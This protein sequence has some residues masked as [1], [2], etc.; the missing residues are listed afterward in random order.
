MQQI[1]QGLN[2]S[3]RRPEAPSPRS[4]S[5]ASVTTSLPAP[6][7]VLPPHH[8]AGAYTATPQSFRLEIADDQRSVARR[9][10]DRP[11]ARQALFNRRRMGLAVCAILAGC[12]LPLALQHGVPGLFEP[13]GLKLPPATDVAQTFGLGLDQVAISGNRF[14][15][16][17]AI[18]KALDLDNVRTLAAFDPKAAREKLEALA[19]VATAELTR[20][21][22][23]QLEVR[24]TE[25]EAFALW[26]HSGREVLIDRTGRELQDVAAGSVTHLPVI[27]GED[28]PRAA[29]ALMVLLTRYQPLAERFS[30]AERVNGRRWSI[31]LQ[32]GG[33]IE[34][35][36][37]GEAMALAELEAGGILQFLLSGTPAVIDLRAPGRVAVRTL[38]ATAAGG[39]SPRTLAGI[40]SLNEHMAQRGGGR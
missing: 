7:L 22:P 3:W 27:S 5:P 20:V 24:I 14:T 10:P 26:R 1:G 32:G 12:A 17:D 28:A 34:L 38:P 16:D 21:Y 39:G 9:A 40:G 19:W 11:V 30:S 8:R 4:P 33:R 35:P 18:F 31:R 23:G 2:S 36:P 37:D 15:S 13:I 6:N 25:R 29:E